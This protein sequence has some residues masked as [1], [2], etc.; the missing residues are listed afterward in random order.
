[1]RASERTHGIHNRKR[2]VAL[3]EDGEG[4]SWRARSM[5]DRV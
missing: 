4:W 2:S 1:M 3:F 5:R